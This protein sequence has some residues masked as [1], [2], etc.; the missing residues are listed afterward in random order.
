MVTPVGTPNFGAI[1]LSYTDIPPVF[2][3]S[4]ATIDRNQACYRRRSRTFAS[5]DGRI[6]RQRERERALWIYAQDERSL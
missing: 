1:V 3:G 2:L 5:A 4:L 6:E